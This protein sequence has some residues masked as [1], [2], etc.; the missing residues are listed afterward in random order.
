VLIFDACFYTEAT[1]II[2]MAY[3]NGVH[4]LRNTRIPVI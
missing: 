2:L 3:H 4:R 1:N